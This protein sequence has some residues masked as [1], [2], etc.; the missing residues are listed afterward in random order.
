MVELLRGPW[1]V[2]SFNYKVAAQ[3]Q[4]NFVAKTSETGNATKISAEFQLVSETCKIVLVYNFIKLFATN[5]SMYHSCVLCMRLLSSV[6]SS[7]L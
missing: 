5:F 6:S 4:A 7:S 2:A 1:S 3:L